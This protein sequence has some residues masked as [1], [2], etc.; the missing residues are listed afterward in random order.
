M[1]RIHLKPFSP[2]YADGSGK[3]EEAARRCDMPGCAAGG[4]HK[5]PKSR[6]L[7]DYYWF[8]YQHV[9]E[10][11]RAWDF[12]SGM[13]QKD[14]EGQI[15]RSTLWD[16]DTRRYDG[17][18]ALEANLYRKAW[19]TYHFTEKKPPK[20]KTTVGI[21][22]DSPE[23]QAMAIMG[24][25]PPLAMTTIKMRYKELVKKYHPD[26]NRDDPGAEELLKSINMAYTI[27]KIACEK[28]EKMNLSS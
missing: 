8:C 17:M 6:S 21:S 24:L 13:S 16:R 11:N 7:S 23:F 28:Y 1:P 9:E 12:F 20:E 5:A 22:S 27:L 26:V 25:E 10:Y 19:Q 18:A 4:T 2:E 15:V 14:I 3:A